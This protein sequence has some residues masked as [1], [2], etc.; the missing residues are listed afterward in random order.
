[1][2]SDLDPA[3]KPILHP[4]TAALILGV[5]W[6]FF[7]AEA[8][9]LGGSVVFTSIAAFAI[10]SAGVFWIQRSRSGD[11]GARAA[12]KALFSGAVAGVPTSIGGTILGTLILAMAGLRRGRAA[13]DRG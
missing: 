7:G 10:T 1:M 11:S 9:T 2:R 6:I 4:L 5:D 12:L 13:P 3:R 8:M